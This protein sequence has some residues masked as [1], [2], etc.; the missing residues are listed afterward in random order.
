M[1]GRL[2]LAWGGLQDPAR[3]VSSRTTVTEAA[4]PASSG[5]L[6][7]C[8]DGL[9]PTTKLIMD[10]ASPNHKGHL[11]PTSSHLS[12]S[13]ILKSLFAVHLKLLSVPWH[14]VLWW[15]NKT[16]VLL[17]RSLEACGAAPDIVENSKRKVG[18]ACPHICVCT[19]SYRTFI[20]LVAI[21][22]PGQEEARPSALQNGQ[23]Q[24]AVWCKAVPAVL[25][26]DFYR[27]RSLLASCSPDMPGGSNMPSRTAQ[28]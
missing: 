20:L 17:V 5:L 15:M 1:S 9:S 3:E 26:T 8:T 14:A 23:H 21:S 16:A 7:L 19:P 4:R 6:A 22:S 28:L 11:A 27:Q 25:P 18:A 10:A 24:S 13:N 2:S 12:D